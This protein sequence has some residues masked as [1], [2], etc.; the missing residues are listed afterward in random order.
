MTDLRFA[1]PRCWSE[2]DSNRRSLLD[3]LLLGTVRNPLVFGTAVP[4]NRVGENFAVRLFGNDHVESPASG[5]SVKM[6]SAKRTGSSN[7]LRS[8]NEAP[9]NRCVLWDPRPI[10]S[11]PRRSRCERAN[12]SRFR[13]PSPRGGAGI[14][15]TGHKGHGRGRSR[16]AEVPAPTSGLGG[17]I[18]ASMR[19]AATRP[20]AG[21]EGGG[22][23]S[24]RCIWPASRCRECGKAGGVVAAEEVDHILPKVRGGRDDE[25]NL[26][27][28]CKSHHSQKTAREVGFARGIP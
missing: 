6:R 5:L 15:H 3:L 8:S 16:H 12:Q 28:L 24:G 20:S 13:H 26:Q 18:G 14:G 2:G 1:V 27:S 19:R 21:T 9:A 10:R 22:R 23:R 4:M 7:P 25:N 17:I 11:K